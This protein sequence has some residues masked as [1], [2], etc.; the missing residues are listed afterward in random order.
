MDRFE[1][2]I[3][4]QLVGQKVTHDCDTCNDK[5]DFVIGEDGFITCTKCNSKRKVD[6]TNAIRDLKKL[7]VSLN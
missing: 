4:K 5:G 6:L 7:G 3:L 2:A 1:K